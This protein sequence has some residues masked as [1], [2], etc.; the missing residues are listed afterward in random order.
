MRARVRQAASHGL[1]AVPLSLVLALALD[2][3]AIARDNGEGL[4]G[5]T[6]D[7]IV[8]AFGLGVVVFFLVVVVLG[9]MIQDGLERRKDAR[10]AAA[11]RQRTSW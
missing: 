7:K 1:T 5:E 3:P 8:T 9:S 4:L 11:L 2:V 10:K 6:D